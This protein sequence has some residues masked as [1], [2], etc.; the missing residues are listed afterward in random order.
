MVMVLG[1]GRLVPHRVVVTHDLDELDVRELLR[2]SGK[3]G[4]H[5]LARAT[6]FGG[7]LHRHLVP[8]AGGREGGGEQGNVR[9]ISQCFSS[10]L[11]EA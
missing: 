11:S 9:V 3:V 8:C 1:R 4:V 2:K 6:R 10:V 7:Y 5:H